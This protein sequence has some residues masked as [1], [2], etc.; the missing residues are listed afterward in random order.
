MQEIV[1]NSVACKS[2]IFLSDPSVAR[3]FALQSA[4][5]TSR[6]VVKIRKAEHVCKRKEK[7]YWVAFVRP[8]F[9]NVKGKTVFH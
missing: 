3:L 1:N 2:V 5:S 8:V 9:F 6:K 7:K 4:K